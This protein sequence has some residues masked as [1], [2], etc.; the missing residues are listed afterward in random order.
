MGDYAKKPRNYKR[1]RCL[2]FERICREEREAG[3]T[4]VVASE[5]AVCTA[6]F[7][8]LCHIFVLAGLEQP[9]AAC[10]PYVQKV[11]DLQGYRQEGRFWITDGITDDQQNLI[12]H[13]IGQCVSRTR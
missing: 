2:E 8:C 6:S 4:V 11:R 10:A 3:E 1:G 13:R 12:R 5:Q 7:P 9:C